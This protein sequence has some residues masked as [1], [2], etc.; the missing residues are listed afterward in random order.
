MGHVR[1][2]CAIARRLRDRGHEVLLAFGDLA[3]LGDETL[4]GIDWVQ[5]P[6]L[7]LPADSDP[8]PLN[9]SDILLSLGFGDAHAL[10]GALTGWLALLRLWQPHALVA[11][12]APGAMLAARIAGLPRVTVGSG[13]TVPRWGAPMP[14]MRDWIPTDASLLAER[15]ARLLASVRNAC[16]RQTVHATPL[17]SVR[18]L[19]DA[20]AHF[21][22]A[23]PEVDP[24]GPREGVEY[25]GP[26]SDATL[27]PRI[28]WQ[29]EKRP[30]IFAYL[31]PRDARFG[32]LLEAFARTSGEA[33][34]AAP[35][36]AA[37]QAA[38]LSRGSVRVLGHPV[39]L[40]AVLA[41]ADLCVSHA[42]AGIV[43]ASAAAGVPMALLPMQLEQYLIAR[44]AHAAGHAELLAPEEGSPDLTAWLTG[45]L[46][47]QDLRAGAAAARGPASRAPLDATERIERAVGA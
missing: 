20:D 44:R 38:A 18:E 4:D 21:V 45:I 34:V 43:A 25:V 10:S 11:D 17:T 41:E 46:T 31:K 6:N 32:A 3:A 19:F 39:A 29:S 5:A 15:D 13:F 12:Y 47:R 42:G 7:P 23:W 28:G 30:R 33:I 37:A 9:A 24:F 16:E 26:Q 36:L 14:A 1:R 2:Q 8:S 22:C 40:D 35:G 27:Q